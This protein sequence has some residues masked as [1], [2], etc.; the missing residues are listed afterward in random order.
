MFV[1]F[2]KDISRARALRES[3]VV[4]CCSPM[5]ATYLHCIGI[6]LFIAG[7]G[8]IPNERVACETVK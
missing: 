1:C 6:Q 5:N 3:K 8:V 7:G 2:F 4:P